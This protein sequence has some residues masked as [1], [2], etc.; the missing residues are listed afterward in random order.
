M[1]SEPV[2]D[3][4][5]SGLIEKSKKEFEYI[6]ENLKMELKELQ[7]MIDRILQAFRNMK[8]KK[9]IENILQIQ[10][11]FLRITRSLTVAYSD[12]FSHTI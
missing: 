3:L 10:E 2:E 11:D 9:D 4:F 12:S 8:Q 6:M 5:F 7:D 1:D